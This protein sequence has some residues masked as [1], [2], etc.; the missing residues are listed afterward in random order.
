M[1]RKEQKREKKGLALKCKYEKKNKR[2]PKSRVSLGRTK[3]EN[4][5][6]VEKSENKQGQKRK[7]CFRQK[8][9]KNKGMQG[10][11]GQGHSKIVMKDWN[12]FEQ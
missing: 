5:P 4:R 9:V 3:N 12:S 11:G 7:N 8:M 2:L 10:G 6:K 1:G